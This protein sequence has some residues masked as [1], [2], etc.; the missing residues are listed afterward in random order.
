MGK[1]IDEL[2]QKINMAIDEVRD[3]IKS[4]ETKKKVHKLAEDTGEIV[5][6]ATTMVGNTVN[7]IIDDLNR[8][9]EKGRNK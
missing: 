3:D 8:G 7:S 6:H 9:F 1:K 4:P 2:S 5:G